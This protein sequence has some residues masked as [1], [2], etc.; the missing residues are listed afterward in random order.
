M[1]YGKPERR[2]FPGHPAYE[3]DDR[4]NVYSVGS[5]R[6]M[7]LSFDGK[8]YSRANLTIAPGKKKHAKVHRAVCEAFHGAPP[9]PRM[10]AAHANGIRNDNRKENLSWKTPA[11]NEA[12]KIETGTTNRGERNGG[13]RLKPEQVLAIRTSTGTLRSLATEFQISQAQ[14]HN[15]R[16]G[17]AWRHL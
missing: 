6:P 16:T 8:G 14:I 12:D 10:H 2:P 5:D 13:C 3:V 11:G 1:T 9:S 7:Y 4:G 17:K 15:I